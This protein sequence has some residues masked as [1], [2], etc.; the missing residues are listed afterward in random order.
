M[1]PELGKG[2]AGK[3]EA[4]LVEVREAKEGVS[5]G[6]TASSHSDRSE[7]HGHRGQAG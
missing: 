3:R 5:R 1:G 7:W 6:F 2:E 4:G